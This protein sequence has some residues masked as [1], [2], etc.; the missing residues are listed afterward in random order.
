M[1][2]STNGQELT[3]VLSDISLHHDPD[4]AYRAKAF[5]I[6]EEWLTH[7]GPQKIEFYGK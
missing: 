5:Q 4:G 1:L 3:L 2:K 6:V 7:G